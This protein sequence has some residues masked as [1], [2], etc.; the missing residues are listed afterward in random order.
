MN[1]RF[2]CINFPLKMCMKYL[3]QICVRLQKRVDFRLSIISYQFNLLGF[4]CNKYLE[5]GCL[6]MALISFCMEIRLS[7]LLIENFYSPLSK[8]NKQHCKYANRWFTLLCIPLIRMYYVNCIQGKPVVF[9]VLITYITN[10]MKTLYV[11][12][13]D[14]FAIKR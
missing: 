6:H 10:K 11:S 1:H 9:T 8:M 14:F 2:L 5:S 3:V 13:V 12:S 7:Y 4:V